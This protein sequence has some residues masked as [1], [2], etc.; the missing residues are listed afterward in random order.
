MN[1]IIT[2]KISLSVEGMTCASCVARVEKTI[3]KYGGVTNVSVN[4]ATEKATFEYSPD[5]VDLKKL[6]DNIEEIGYKLDLSSLQK[7]KSDSETNHDTSD[8]YIKEL[9]L[10]LIHIS[11][12]TRPY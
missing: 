9:K 2:E 8:L 12:P 10:S 4:L 5:T 6:A 11:E 1:K 7:N 3:S